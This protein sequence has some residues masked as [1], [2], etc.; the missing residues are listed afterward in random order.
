MVVTA[1]RTI[2]VDD[3]DADLLSKANNLRDMTNLAREVASR[4]L[5]PKPSGYHVGHIDNDLS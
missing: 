4:A 2:T 1:T 5:G 3:E